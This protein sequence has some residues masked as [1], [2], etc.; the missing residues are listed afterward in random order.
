[1]IRDS[2]L[3]IA[4]NGGGDVVITKIGVLIRKA[5]AAPCGVSSAAKT[6]VFVVSLIVVRSGGAAAR[7]ILTRRCDSAEIVNGILKNGRE[8]VLRYTRLYLV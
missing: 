4:V 3:I 7:T 5:V 6:S 8:W 1:M 2:Y